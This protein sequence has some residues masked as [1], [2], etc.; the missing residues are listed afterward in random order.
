MVDHTSGVPHNG[1]DP[2]GGDRHRLRHDADHLE[3]CA[4]HRQPHGRQGRRCRV[5]IQCLLCVK[6][7]CDLV[8]QKD[9]RAGTLAGFVLR[10]GIWRL[11]NSCW[12]SMQ[13]C[14]C[15]PALPLP[16]CAGSTEQLRAVRHI[17][18]VPRHDVRVFGLLFHAEQRYRFCT[19]LGLYAAF[20]NSAA[21][22]LSVSQCPSELA[23][24]IVLGLAWLSCA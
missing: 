23:V 9:S 11:N 15:V 16:R 20:P 17:S 3:C 21:C 13:V 18:R 2:V 4:R 24:C 22:M 14:D 6:W 19:R 8:Q 10:L 12:L 1:A 5:R 7:V